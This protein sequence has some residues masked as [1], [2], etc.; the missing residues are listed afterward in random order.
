MYFIGDVHGK[1]V[2]YGKILRN[3]PIGEKSLQ[4]GDM[5]LGFKGVKL[6]AQDGQKY[7]VTHKFI[8][9]NHDNPVECRNHSNYAGDFGYWKPEELFFLGGAWSIDQKWRVEGKTWWRDEELDMVELGQATM[10]YN[11]VKPR[12][13]ATHEAPTIA[14]MVMLDASIPLIRT[15]YLD[16]FKADREKGP[17]YDQWK[18]TVGFANTRTSQA[19]Q[20]M[21]EY[22]QPEIWVYGHYHKKHDFI[23]KG[24]HFYCLPELDV[25]EI[26][27]HGNE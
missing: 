12:I 9:G 11:V 24:T 10:L 17:E 23:Y 25:M 21:L 18:N 16:S 2:E 1:T 8:R 26:K 14:A 20:N 4:V 19:L 6:P 15:T 13:V 5:G 27:T 3:L 7:P 22:H